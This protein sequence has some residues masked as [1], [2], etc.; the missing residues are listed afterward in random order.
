MRRTILL[1]FAITISSC[2]SDKVESL[3]SELIKKNDSIKIQQN[4]IHEL[5][6]QLSKIN[7]I[8]SLTEEEI[9]K[10]F[11]N[12]KEFSTPDG[13]RKNF[14]L[15]KIDENKYHIRYDYRNKKY[16]S[17]SDWSTSIYQIEFFPNDKYR[18]SYIKGNEF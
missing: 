3:E 17:Y 16:M 10:I 18:L 9:I 14:E 13:E 15:K 2:N 6:I 1:L 11:R 4:K 5:E 7:R 8:K 12:D